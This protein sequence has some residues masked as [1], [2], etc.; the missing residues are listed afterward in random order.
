MP[1]LKDTKKPNSNNAG[2]KIL[3][4]GDHDLSKPGVETFV[5]LGKT[6]EQ[7]SFDTFMFLGDYGYEFY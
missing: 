3:F 2:L 7:E 5:A 4:F 6:L 1:P